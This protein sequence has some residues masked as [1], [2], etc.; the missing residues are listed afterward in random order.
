MDIEYSEFVLFL[1][2][3][4]KNNLRYMC[5]GGYAVNYYGY[6]RVTEDLDIWIAPTNENKFSFLST[7]LCMGYSENEI[8]YIKEEDFTSYF[9]ITIGARPHVI[10]LLTIVHKNIV[11]DSAEKEMVIHSIGEGVE[12]KIVSYDFLK[13]IK[14]RSSRP[15]DQWD[16]AR[17][18]E[19]R[20]LKKKS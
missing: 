15:K 19:L 7:L 4:K 5:I 18:E 14:L 20:N 2:C 1:I 16:I 10:D 12:L 6:H 3:A 13:D 8:S 11:F 9:M 17:L